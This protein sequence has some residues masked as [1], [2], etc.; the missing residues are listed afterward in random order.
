MDSVSN[1]IGKYPWLLIPVHFV[2]FSSVF[3][4]LS[5]LLAHSFV[6]NRMLCSLE[7]TLSLWKIS[8]SKNSSAFK[9]F[10]VLEAIFSSLFRK[11]ATSSGFHCFLCVCC[12]KIRHKQMDILLRR[13]QAVCS[14]LL[15]SSSEQI[16]LAAGIQAEN[17]YNGPYF[18]VVSFNTIQ[19]ANNRLKISQCSLKHIRKWKTCLI[20][21]QFSTA[22]LS[23][24]IVDF[25]RTL[26][27]F[28]ASMFRC[29]IECILWYIS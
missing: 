23:N 20:Y 22:N 5:I 4:S 7:I 2:R 27:V 12:V 8:Y 24:A 9:S 1:Q 29:N 16:E 15:C 28:N 13:L 14:P 19:E 18:V 10:F 6:T 3:L 26:L 11:Y 21:R 25:S 17:S